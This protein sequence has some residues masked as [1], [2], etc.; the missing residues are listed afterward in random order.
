[1][2]LDHYLQTSVVVEAMKQSTATSILMDITDNLLRQVADENKL[3]LN[4]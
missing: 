1:M 4:Y 2:L 3:E